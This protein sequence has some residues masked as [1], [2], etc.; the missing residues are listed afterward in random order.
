MSS[1]EAG[2]V[3]RDLSAIGE[4]YDREILRRT[5][6]AADPIAQ[7]DTWFGDWLT[8]P[9]PDPAACVLATAG[10]DGRPSARWVLCRS[11]DER[12]FVFY[13]NFESR[14][15]EDL[16]ANPWAALTFAWHPQHR[17]V[18]IEG[19]VTVVDDAEA[20]AYWESRPRASRI[21]AWA[22]DQSDVLADRLELERHVADAE[23]RFGAGESDGPVPRPPFW[24][25]Y[26]VGVETAEFWQGRPDRLHDRFRYR[27]DIDAV[28]DDGPGPWVIDRLSP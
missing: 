16:E 10:A 9:H 14:K 25:G 5:D 13:T 20:D 2:P 15:A 27:R 22:S 6:L 28:G 26:R 19:P 21:G 12:G 18:R 8:E 17:Q 4:V 1:D 23:A 11:Y 24:G 3:G 7:F